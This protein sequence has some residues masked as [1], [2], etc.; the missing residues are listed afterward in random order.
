LHAITSIRNQKSALAPL[1]QRTVT[2]NR[3]TPTTATTAQIVTASASATPERA[4]QAKWSSPH[5]GAPTCSGRI[6]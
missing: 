6:G 2:Q 5:H 3:A 4:R 1:K